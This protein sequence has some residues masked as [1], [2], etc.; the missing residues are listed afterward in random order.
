MVDRM[1]EKLSTE[2]IIARV[3][4]MTISYED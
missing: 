4:K 1:R 3:M 2:Q